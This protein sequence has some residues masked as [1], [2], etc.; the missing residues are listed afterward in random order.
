LIPIGVVA[1]DSGVTIEFLE[2]FGAGSWWLGWLGV[3]AG[4]SVVGAEEE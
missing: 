2:K 3:S 4:A 1:G